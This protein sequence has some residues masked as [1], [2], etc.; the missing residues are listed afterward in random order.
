MSF[1][2]PPPPALDLVDLQ[3][4]YN[5]H[6][7]SATESPLLLNMYAIMLNLIHENSSINNQLDEPHRMLIDNLESLYSQAPPPQQPITSEHSEV[8]RNQVSF[9]QAPTIAVSNE[10]E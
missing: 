7:A 8:Q 2:V 9:F 4:T 1:A 5:N 3:N 6:Q 10:N